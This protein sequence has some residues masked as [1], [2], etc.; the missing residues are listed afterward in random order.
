MMSWDKHKANAI[1]AIRDK[2]I[3]ATWRLRSSSTS[4]YIP[5]AGGS[6]WGCVASFTGWNSKI[7]QLIVQLPTPEQ[8]LHSSY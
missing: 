7:P 5:L 3:R 2:L 8:P 4:T 6:N 1:T